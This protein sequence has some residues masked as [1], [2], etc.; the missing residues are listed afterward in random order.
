[1][2]SP[3]SGAFRSLRSVEAKSSRA[4]FSSLF[5]ERAFQVLKDLDMF[6]IAASD[7]LSKDS[8]RKLAQQQ[9]FGTSLPLQFRLEKLGLVGP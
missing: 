1:V 7:R 3:D 5:A 8:C 2:R 6:R 4:Q 9:K